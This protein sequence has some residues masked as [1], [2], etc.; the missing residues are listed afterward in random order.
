MD[1]SD[2]RLDDILNARACHDL[3]DDLACGLV[4]GLLPDAAAVVLHFGQHTDAVRAGELDGLPAD[5]LDVL[6]VKAADDL[7]VRVV[8]KVEDRACGEVAVVREDVLHDEVFA[9]YG[10]DRPFVDVQQERVAGSVALKGAAINDEGQIIQTQKIAK[11]IKMETGEVMYEVK[12]EIIDNGDPGLGSGVPTI[13]NGMT[14]I[15]EPTEQGLTIT[16]IKEQH[17][18]LFDAN[19]KMIFSKHLSA[20]ENVTLPTGVY[21]VRGEYEQVKAIK[22]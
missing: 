14:L 4:V 8:V 20:E 16:P 13:M 5:L 18:M 17:V 3:V 1:G 22:K 15:V 21:V 19:G 9:V 2:V 11:A 12:T 7:T 6:H 10:L